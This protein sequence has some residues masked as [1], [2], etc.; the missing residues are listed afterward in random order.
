MI[1][2]KAP[3]SPTRAPGKHPICRRQVRYWSIC[4][5]SDTTRVI[6]C[7]ADYQPR[8]SSSGY[9]TYVISDPDE[10]PANATAANGVTW[11][12][13]GGIFPS[14]V[15]ILPQH[16]ARAVFAQAVQYGQRNE[17]AASR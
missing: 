13:W 8:R 16:A 9:Y 17:L 11:L 12:P 14:G 2:G 1:H 3:T 4:E 15:V 5:N 7:A 10:R 6:S